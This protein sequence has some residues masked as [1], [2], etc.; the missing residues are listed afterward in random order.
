VARAMASYAE[1]LRRA[2]LGVPAQ[3]T[4]DADKVA[5]TAP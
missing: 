4:G 2:G 1:L 5:G 3:D